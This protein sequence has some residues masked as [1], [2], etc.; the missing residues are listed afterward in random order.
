MHHHLEKNLKNVFLRGQCPKATNRTQK[1]DE[2]IKFNSTRIQENTTKALVFC[3]SFDITK[4]C[5]F[6]N[7]FSIVSRRITF[8]QR[9]TLLI[10]LSRDRIASGYVVLLLVLV[11]SIILRKFS[12][13]RWGTNKHHSPFCRI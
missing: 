1:G 10:F 12:M 7:V 11:H 13:K 4:G 5:K 2:R 6:T 3:I 8:V 9:K